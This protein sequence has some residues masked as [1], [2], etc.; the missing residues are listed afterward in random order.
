MRISPFVRRFLTFTLLAPFILVPPAALGGYREETHATEVEIAQLPRFC[1]AQFEVPNATGDEFKMDNRCPGANHYCPGLI[2]LIRA[3]GHVSKGERLG[4]LS[5]AEGD[6]RRT[7]RGINDYPTC[8]ISDH[9]AA[10]RAQVNNHMVLFGLKRR[11][12]Q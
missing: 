7:E 9:V 5:R 10:S 6:I 2:Y 12:A 8:S 11:G 3:K 4:L 1:W